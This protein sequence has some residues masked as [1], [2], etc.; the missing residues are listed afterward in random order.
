MIFECKGKKTVK[1]VTDGAY[2]YISLL[3]M[4]DKE[5]HLLLRTLQ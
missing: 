3:K 2:R 1:V 5:R 4:N